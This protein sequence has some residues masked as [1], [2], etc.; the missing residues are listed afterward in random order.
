MAECDGDEL[1][2]GHGIVPSDSMAVSNPQDSNPYPS[3]S[4]QKLEKRNQTSDLRDE[5]VWILP[6]QQQI[7][8]LYNAKRVQNF[9][10]CVIVLN[11]LVSV[12]Q[13]EILPEAGSTGDTVFKAFEWTFNI[14]FL[15]ELVLNMYAFFFRPFWSNNWNIFDFFIVTVSWI[16]MLAEFPGIAVL[17]LFRA[18]R[19]FRLFKRIP[20]LQ[21]IVT[22][23]LKSLPGMV[24]AIAVLLLVMG[25]WS[26]MGV[27]FFGEIFPDEFG[28]F[29]KGML[30][31]FQMMTYDS[32]V[33][34]VTRPICLYY[35]T[36]WPPFFFVS[37]AF[38]SAIIM[39]NVLIAILVDKYGEAVSEMN[40]DDEEEEVQLVLSNDATEASDEAAEHLCSKTGEIRKLVDNLLTIGQDVEKQEK[41]KR[42]RE[43]VKYVLPYQERVR[44]WF[45]TDNIQLYM[46]VAIFINFVAAAAEAQTLPPEGTPGATICLAIEWSFNVWFLF[47]ILVNMYGNWCFK[48]KNFI[49]EFWL[50]YWN[51]FDFGIVLVSWIMS[52]Q[53]GADMTVLR[54]FRAF[55]RS[56]VAFRVVK[57]LR[58]QWV[59][60]IVI[61]VLKSLPGVSNAFV[62]LGLI[63]GIWSIMGVEFYREDFP[64]EFG[65]FFRAMLTML[66]IMSF[67]SWSSGITRPILTHEN[68]EPVKGSL[69]FILYMFA[70]S[71]IIANVV[72]AILLDRFLAAAKEEEARMAEAKK[73]GEG[74]EQPE[75][76]PNAL[77]DLLTK[78]GDEVVLMERSILGP[79]SDRAGSVS[80]RVKPQDGNAWESD[81]RAALK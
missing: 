59:K 77:V 61:G 67:D 7:F 80:E 16:S 42:E 31:C 64:D 49:P 29:T 38:I 46:A 5:M 8:A 79:L 75:K 48:G 3:E 45:N 50:N 9:V 24:N 2:N 76:P 73:A 69:F 55:R 35:G 74:D 21:I 15:I 34:G 6:G 11:Y 63:M 51:V 19:V 26:I 81:T 47:E 18:F 70:S 68:T 25:V 54:L 33:S 14:I 1:A 10:V 40:N 20:S 57:L 36:P 62:L 44:V 22:G 56:I 71:I 66:Q 32:W 53:T 30:T 65:N 28:N 58:L 72:L 43:A 12:T 27:H 23:V 17:R 78:L 60:V 4:S 37:Y 39:A 52:L 13:V 41:E